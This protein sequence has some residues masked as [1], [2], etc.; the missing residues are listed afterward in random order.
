M[1]ETK[2]LAGMLKSF[3]G[4]FV[5]LDDHKAQPQA[6]ATPAISGTPKSDPTPQYD[7]EMLATLNSV[8][9]KRPTAYTALL[10]MAKTFDGIIDDN[11]MKIKAAFKAISQRENRSPRDVFQAI[12]IH[13]NDIDNERKRFQQAS[14]QQVEKAVGEKRDRSEKLKSDAAQAKQRV[15]ELKAEIEQLTNQSN[16]SL[17]QADQLDH[18]AAIEE[19]KINEVCQ[20]FEITA[21]YLKRDLA[22]KK[23]QLSSILK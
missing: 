6:T 3:T 2:G 13:T 21:E 11:T 18:D 19:Q 1:A 17:Q 16:E 5:E 9:T 4:V 10:E 14:H 8:I 7:Q 12:D 15:D 22:D 20:R 23:S